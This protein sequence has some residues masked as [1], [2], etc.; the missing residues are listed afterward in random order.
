MR[1]VVMQN[2]EPVSTREYNER[3]VKV[4]NS[5]NMKANLEHVADNATQLNSGERTQLISLLKYFED[6]FYVTIGYWKTDP[7]D[8]ELKPDSKL[9][10]CKYHPVPRI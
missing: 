1:R 3:L 8:L 10:N 5:A 9:L 6:L 7:V 4:L 2:T